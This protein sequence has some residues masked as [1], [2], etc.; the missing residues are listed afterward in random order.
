MFPAAY[1]QN[2]DGRGSARKQLHHVLPIRLRICKN[3]T[4][5]QNPFTKATRWSAF[6]FVK[7]SPLS[8]FENSGGNTVRPVGGAQKQCGWTWHEA[9]NAIRRTITN[10]GRWLASKAQNRALSPN[11]CDLHRTR[12]WPILSPSSRKLRWRE[13][14]CRGKTCRSLRT[15][16]AARRAYC[17]SKEVGV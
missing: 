17:I 3:G 5:L 10:T 13:A 7:S 4:Q 2:I 1:L 9:Q 16:N 14:T 15:I 6:L 12:K 11:D 8:L